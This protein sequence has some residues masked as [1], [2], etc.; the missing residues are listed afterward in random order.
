M[1]LELEIVMVYVIWDVWL[2]M[3]LIY[4]LWCKMKDEWNLEWIMVLN[5]WNLVMYE[6]VM[7]CNKKGIWNV[8]GNMV[9]YMF[10]MEKRSKSICWSDQVLNL[11]MD[12]V[13]WSK[14]W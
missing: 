3:I 12:Q 14:S 8:Y 1:Y 11:V 13:P 5:G 2:N 7:K 6:S 10:E 9:E 4:G